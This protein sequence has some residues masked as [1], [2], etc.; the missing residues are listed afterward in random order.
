MT[1]YS[2]PVKP[3][4]AINTQWSEDVPSFPMNNSIIILNTSLSLNTGGAT[5]YTEIG[6]PTTNYT[7][8]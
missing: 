1:T 7:E 5:A 3:R 6:K 2:E 4:E 8:D